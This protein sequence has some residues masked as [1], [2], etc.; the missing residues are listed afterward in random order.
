MFFTELCIALFPSF[1]HP[2]STKYSL[3]IN[4]LYLVP[5]LPHVECVLQDAEGKDIQL[6]V[7]AQGLLVYKDK[8]QVNRFVWPKV[9]KMSYRRSKFFVK[10][11]PGEVGH[12]SGSLC[13]VKP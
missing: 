6:G 4:C 1:V 9:L 2:A 7:C 11:R 5:V 8:V 10:I 13:L 12:T 3:F